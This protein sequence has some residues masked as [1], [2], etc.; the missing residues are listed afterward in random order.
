MP[1]HR[2]V[3]VLAMLTT[4]LWPCSA[5]NHDGTVMILWYHDTA[6]VRLSG[7]GPD[8]FLVTRNIGQGH[9]SQ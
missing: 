9:A 2:I 8:N 7:S 5:G 3:A 6:P 1:I 4:A